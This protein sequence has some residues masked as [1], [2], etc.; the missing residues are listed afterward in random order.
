MTST[1]N[2]AAR[3]R[4]G[5][6][7]SSQLYPNDASVSD[8]YTVYNYTDT[9]TK[10]GPIPDWRKRISSGL[11]ASTSL[12]GSKF[13][14]TQSPG[15]MT[16]K[17]VRQPG[18]SASQY[19]TAEYI[20]E[21]DCCDFTLPT[22]GSIVNNTSFDRA[23]NKALTKYY[24]HAADIE[25]RFKGMVFTGELR[26]SLRMIRSPAKALRNGIGDYLTFLQ[27]RG[28]RVPRRK[29]RSFVRETWLEYSFGWKPLISDID[30]AIQAFY[31]SNLVHP[32]FEMVSGWGKDELTE[33][34]AAVQKTLG[35]L[36]WYYRLRHTESY[37]VRYYGIIRSTGNG[38]S[39]NHTYGFR[40]AE[41]IPTVW[42]L[43]PYSFLV[44]YFTNIGDIVSSWSYRFIAPTVVTRLRRRTHL[45]ET[46]DQSVQ[47]AEDDDAFFKYTVT[48]QPG[49]VGF[50]RVNVIRDPELTSPLPSF[51]CQVPGFGSVKWLNL[52]A[53]SKQLHGARRSLA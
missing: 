52:L 33:T 27:K 47:P 51:E 15:R 46:T 32:I 5:Y 9:V 40:P 17:R 41:F 37:F 24:S 14:L 45:Y 36:V 20:A 34:S 22:S 11:L 2:T 7:A 29:R 6:T 39:D 48:G 30:G 28:K 25:T 35:P 26:E 18:L 44:D 38:V 23:S 13:T 19:P 16:W 49:S 8:I 1:S 4:V 3:F 42:E 53:L 12:S 31:T 10:G 43:I 50:S 21:G